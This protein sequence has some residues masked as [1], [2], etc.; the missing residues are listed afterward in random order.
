MR[1][2]LSDEERAGIEAALVRERRVR[3][4]RRYQAIRLLAEGH[5]PRMVAATLGV[6]VA[7]VYNWAEAWRRRKHDGMKESARPG[8]TRRLDTAAEGMLATWLAAGPRAFGHDADLWT[9]PLLRTQLARRGY[10]CSEHTLRRALHRLGW[11][12][13]GSGYVLAGGRVRLAAG[14]GDRVGTVDTAGTVG[15]EPGRAPPTS[16]IASPAAGGLP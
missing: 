2:E 6:S 9:V 5:A 15:K 8:R 13:H 3:H 16:T 11:R 12:W 10:A 7:S 14:E 4:W 1:I